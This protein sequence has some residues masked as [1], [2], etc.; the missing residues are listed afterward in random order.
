MKRTTLF[1]ALAAI[2]T[3]GVTARVH[4]EETARWERVPL[5]VPLIVGQ[6]RVLFV[7]HPL[8]V[9][10][11]E[12]LR[13]RLRAQSAGGALYL[14]ASARFDPTRVQVE[15]IDTGEVI[16]LDV[17]ASAPKTRQH[18][19]E[20]LRVVDAEHTHPERAAPSAMSERSPTTVAVRPDT[21][22]PVAL[23]RYAAQ[24]LYAPLRTV[25][26]LEGIASVPL[27]H[28][29]SV[30]GLAP[31]L[32]VRAKALCAWRLEDFW[33]TAIRLTNQSS[34]WLALDPRELQGDLWAATFQ[35]QTLGPSGDPTDTTVLYL[36]TR[37]HG[38]AE[39][40]PP[41]ISP[42]DASVNLRRPGVPR[43]E[44]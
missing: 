33:V 39:A 18:P 43:S 24:S 32:A 17:Q 36:V 13:G 7:D 16:L 2:V 35:D 19:L 11:P 40:L 1:A 31:N 21:P 25:E 15:E 14:R 30:D 23:T 3:A 22:I 44:E 6:E 5:N 8:R 27:P 4:G 42:T 20:P 38:L 12:S 29:L 41:A 28:S 26:P 34:R 37:S 9:G 10:V